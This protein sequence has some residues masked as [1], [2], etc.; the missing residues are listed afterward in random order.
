MEQNVLELMQEISYKP[1][2]VDELETALGINSADEFRELVK[3]LNRLEAEGKIVRTRTNRYGLPEHMNL[4]RGRLQVNSKGFGFLI[5]DEKE[6]PD[7][8]IHGSDL[9]GALNGD[10]ALVRI[11]YAPEGK[12]LEGE[13]VRIVQ[14]SHT[15]IVGTYQDAKY[16]G[17]VIP[18]D[19]RITTDLF[20]PK[21][22]TMGAVDG[23]K[24]VVE[25]T[26]YPEG[27]KN[28]EGKIV[29]ILGHKNDPGV[30]I[31]S[32]IRTF[33]LPEQFPEEVMAEATRI[34]DEIAP[35]EI[36]G[37]RD[38]R[39]LTIVTIDGADAKD[40]DD[41]VHVERLP[42]G[43]FRLGVH[44]ADVSYYVKE[45]SP[46][47][48]EA[49]KRGTSVYLV[50][51][52]IPMLPHRL[53]NGICSLNPR[54]DRL[55]LSCV[56][57][58]D[59][60]GNR[61]N[62]D[63][64]PSVIRTVERMTYHDVNRILIDEDPELMKRYEALVPHFK[65]MAELSELLRK[66]RMERGAIDFNFDEAKVI[67]DEE[68]KPV[69]VVLRERNIAEKLIEDFMLAAN[70]TVAEHFSWL[71]LPFV[72]RVHEDPD[73]EKIQQFV[74]FITNFGYL[75]RGTANRIHP[76]ALQQILEQIKG[77]PE[78][79]IISTV[80]LRSMKQ[81]KYSSE[82]DG[83][84]GLAAE[85]YTHFTSPIRR[86]PDLMVHRLIREYQKGEI[87][88]E[89]LE[90]LRG[91][92]GEACEHSSH[93]ERVAMEAERET[94]ALK[95]A[96]YMLDHI[97]EEFEGIISGV[98]SYGLFVRLPNTIEGMVHVSYL[99]DDYYHYHEKLYALIGERTGKVYRIGDPVLVRCTGVS[100]ENKTI[101]F[102][103]VGL[104]KRQ[105][106][107]KR[108]PK[109]IKAFKE[110]EKEKKRKSKGK[111]DKKPK[112]KGGNAPFWAGVAK[113]KKKK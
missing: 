17:F 39:D 105:K 10:I 52:V 12:R 1:M 32:I 8:Y 110:S 30:D 106:D 34:P 107:E 26:R 82:N 28:G 36:Q 38:L 23:H 66:T 45:G 80:L 68:G 100:K 51:R 21:E 5:P 59:E 56:M 25:I 44:I 98:A 113:K 96:E 15:H 90:E 73:E 7:I 22:H 83:H 24:V 111:G 6:H 97:G 11:N 84:Y 16:Y 3:M 41:A 57:E 102:E 64:F 77:S 94:N 35:E 58:F 19:S 18:D 79:M 89:R 104:K 86:Y 85:F 112:G 54:V 60:E 40:L 74:E 70:E 95:M 9:K 87:T 103:L 93:R 71:R 14:R 13:V 2:T 42:N 99:T 92:L 27:R 78:E 29:E 50:D 69:D 43:H 4:I 37:R 109:I 91:K 108:K 75:V 63:I 72:Y 33:N 101:D 88:E 62:Y 53:S 65:L 49:Y 20:I 61:V 46:L 76:R 67:V 48:L 47:D 55:T 31:L 81:A